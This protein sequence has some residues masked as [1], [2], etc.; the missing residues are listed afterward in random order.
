MKDLK[1]AIASDHGG[2]ELKE[3]LIDYLE[4]K[5]EIIDCGPDNEDS[6]DYPDYALKVCK[7]IDKKEVERGILICGT[8]LGMS[9][10]ANKYKGIR[11]AAVSDPFSAK[12][13]IRHNDAQ[14]LCLGGRV[15]GEELAKMIVD[16]YLTHAFDGGRHQRRIDKI[17]EIEEN[18]G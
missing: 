9:Y 15:V 5:Y 12:M 13:A 2:F 17:T 10:S 3:I 7:K 6:V 14:V 16:E 11:A 4:K 8:G 18:H 1:I